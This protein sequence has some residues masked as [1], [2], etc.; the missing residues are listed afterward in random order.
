MIDVFH[1]KGKR[2]EDLNGIVLIFHC[3]VLKTI[4]DKY[5]K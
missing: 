5:L 2:A 1:A 4:L 3:Q